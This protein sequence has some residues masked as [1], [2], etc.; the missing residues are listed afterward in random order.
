MEVRLMADATVIPQEAISRGYM[1]SREAGASRRAANPQEVSSA[2]LSEK[3][4]AALKE[5]NWQKM[6]EIPSQ[7]R[8]DH[9]RLGEKVDKIGDQNLRTQT[10]DSLVGT[11]LA[12]EEGFKG[13]RISQQQQDRIAGKVEETI[14]RNPLLSREYLAI[15]DIQARREFLVKHIEDPRIQRIVRKELQEIAE[16]T[17]DLPNDAREKSYDVQEKT[18]E[19]D[20]MQADRDELDRQ[21]REVDHRLQ[22]FERPAA[23]GHMGARAQELEDLRTT[24]TANRAGHAAQTQ[25]VNNAEFRIRQLTSEREDTLRNPGQTGR[26]PI[27][28]IDNEINTE[29]QNGSAAQAEMTRLTGLIDR[30]PQLEQEEQH[31][32]KERRGLRGERS[33]K[34]F[35][36]GKS[37]TALQRATDEYNDALRRREQAEY[38]LGNRINDVWSSAVIEVA[39]QDLTELAANMR[40]IHDEEFAGLKEGASKAGRDRIKELLD[41]KIETRGWRGKR[42]RTVIDKI[43]TQQI[44]AEIIDKGPEVAA[45]RFLSGA[46]NPET[47]QTYTPEEV[48]ALLKDKDFM[49]EFQP[50]MIKEVFGRK[51]LTSKGFSPEDARKIVE[52]DWG[53]QMVQGAAQRNE[54]LKNKIE[55]IMGIGAMDKPGFAKRLAQEAVKPKNVGLLALLGLLA[56][57]FAGVVGV[58]AVGGGVAGKAGI[59]AYGSGKGHSPVFG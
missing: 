34:N 48:S 55:E 3:M 58:A 5:Q 53:D 31:L 9:A 10:N 46:K 45:R 42:G 8:L 52:S 50:M 20:S 57:P 28:D 6:F 16:A 43:K 35:E 36:L 2:R 25:I 40:R 44:S 12:L 59:G 19:R 18:L 39:N 21:I 24:L 41:R 30:I 13:G 37:N 27:V 7:P 51:L 4:G 32:N 33:A 14:M 15:N 23:G 29:R 17:D 26:R 47:G 11:R 38:A 49:A 56:A 22:E 1:H 54:D